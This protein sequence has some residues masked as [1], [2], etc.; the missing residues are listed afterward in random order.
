MPS[1]PIF[2]TTTKLVLGAC[3][4]GS[5]SL[6]AGPLAAERS[7]SAAGESAK[8]NDVSPSRRIERDGR[9][10]RDTS[11]D[12]NIRSI[13]G[14][15]NNLA[16][17][18]LGATHTH[19]RRLVPSA[20]ADGIAEPSGANRLSARAISNRVSAQSE[21]RPNAAR[22]SDYLWQWG[23]FLD[24]DLD[25]SDG[26][27]PPESFP[28]DVPAGDVH[29]DPAGT[30][31]V[32]IDLNRT[33]YDFDTG[34][35][36]A[37]PREQEN[38][39]TAW[40]DGSNVYGS[41][42]QRATALRS[43]DGSGRLKTS[44]GDFLPYNLEG[45]PNA[46]GSGANLFLAGDVRANEQLGL[47]AMHTLFVREHNRVVAELAANNPRLTGDE[48]YERARARVG[49]LMQAITYNEFLPL[50]LGSRRI[51]S[52]SGYHPTAA[53]GISNVFSGASYRFGH[54]ALNETLLRLGADG[55]SIAEG[56]LALRDA[57]FSPQKLIEEGGIDPVLRGLA[58][59]AAQEIDVFV[60]DSLRNFLFGAP[61]S[62]GFDLV[63]LN[64]QR[65]RDHGLPSYNDARIALGLRP[66]LTFADISSDPEVQARL[67][68]AYGDTAD[69]DVWVGGLAEDPQRGAM[70]GQLISTILTEQFVALRDG[71]RFWFESVLPRGVVYELNNTSLADVIRRNTN[72]G[73]ELPDDVFRVPAERTRKRNRKR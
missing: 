73:S 47:T 4:V 49:G 34:V 14:S 62:G 55:N 70:V 31:T 43:L 50:L 26:T 17:P 2:S 24:H 40:I 56:D 32:Q 16:D 51:G 65:G 36:S 18:S 25:L 27:N 58:G 8:T 3:I 60:V 42:A 66:R 44:E 10:K 59:Q 15:D 6:T 53:K 64:I 72:I 20:Y 41:D 61:G 30:G 38:E 12:R 11:S 68:D 37:A 39:I 54:S 28:I 13:D 71:D 46:G 33:L 22:A 21:S 57:F 9:R 35:S 5:V 29:F 1:A 63:S 23:Q 48:L 69:I 67:A 7:T 19:L 45:L 52:S